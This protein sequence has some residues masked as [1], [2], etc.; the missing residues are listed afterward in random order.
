MKNYDNAD[1]GIC[2]LLLIAIA[3]IATGYVEQGLIGM[4]IGAIAGISR[5]NGKSGGP[6]S[7]K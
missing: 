2:A 4:A 6:E 1:L 3:A 5:S 7:P